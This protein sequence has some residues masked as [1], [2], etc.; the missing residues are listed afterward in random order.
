MATE[1]IYPSPKSQEDNDFDDHEYEETLSLCDLPISSTDQ[2]RYEDDSCK[3]LHQSTSI[4]SSPFSSDEQDLFEFFSE[5]WNIKASPTNLIN[6]THPPPSDQNIIFYG[7]MMIPSH[8]RNQ[9]A[10][11]KSTQKLKASQEIKR[12]LGKYRSST[13]SKG[14]DKNMNEVL[15]P[16]ESIFTSLV[17]KRWYLILLGLPPKIPTAQNELMTDIKNRQSRHAPSTFF[18]SDGGGVGAKVR[19]K[20]DYGSWRLIRAASCFGGQLMQTSV[21]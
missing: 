1:E 19:R 17:R 12:S 8:P 2:D 13:V 3:K 11:S 4:S 15:V 7:K 10:I 18:P 20:N 6:E 14:S 16:R 5:E 9:E 21:L